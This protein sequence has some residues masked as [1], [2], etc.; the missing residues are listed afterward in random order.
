MGEGVREF[1]SR[2]VS[3]LWIVAAAW[4]AYNVVAFTDVT[5]RH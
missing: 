3:L 4:F 2:A 5:L 1:L